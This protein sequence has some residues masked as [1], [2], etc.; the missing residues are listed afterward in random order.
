MESGIKPIIENADNYEGKW[1]ATRSFSDRNV[2]A[3][4]DDVGEVH[5]EAKKLGVDE[6]V[7]VYIPPAGSTLLGGR[8]YIP[9]KEGVEK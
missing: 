3:S 4:G 2:I 6:P 1:V 5:K 8:W 7:I 9:V